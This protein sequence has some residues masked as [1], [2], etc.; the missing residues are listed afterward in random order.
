MKAILDAGALVAVDCRDRAVG[1]H[2][3]VLQQRGTPVRA[4]AAVIGKVWREGRKQ[5]N[6][7][8]VLAGIGIEALGKD[9]GC[10]QGTCSPGG[11]GSSP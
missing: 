6:L 3:R 10:S 4:S 8:H 9:N 7:A 11:T 2:R 5:A 1:A